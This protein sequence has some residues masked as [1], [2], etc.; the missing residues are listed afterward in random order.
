MNQFERNQPTFRQFLKWIIGG[1]AAL[2]ILALLWADR[3]HLA[4]ALN[5]VRDREVVAAY[6]ESLGNWGPLLYLLILGV[7]VITAVIPGHALMI[8]AGYMYGFSEGLILN[9]IGVVGASQLAFVLSRRVGKPFVQWFVPAHL[10][11]RWD[12]MATRQGFFFYLICFWFPI[13]P[14]N[15]TNYIGGLSSISFWLFFLANVAGRLPG[16]IVVTLIGSH[17]FELTGS[18]WGMLALAGLVVIIGGRSL[19]VKIER[20]FS[21]AS[22][23]HPE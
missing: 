19:A 22:L 8:A 6:L 7:Q 4:A 3:D 20:K 2:L 11:H 1:S 9:L 13:I 15:A 23:G 12:G 14:S 18:Q 16:L 21:A 17:G 5:F 10:L